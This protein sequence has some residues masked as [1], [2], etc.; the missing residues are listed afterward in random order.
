MAGKPLS[1]AQPLVQPPRAGVMKA[2]MA[3][4]EDSWETGE[5]GGVGAAAG[6][7]ADWWG[8]HYTPAVQFANKKLITKMAGDSTVGLTVS[9]FGGEKDHALI[10]LIKPALWKKHKGYGWGGRKRDWLDVAL[11]ELGHWALHAHSEEH[12]DEFKNWA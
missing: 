7:L 5:P 2:V 8:L 9:S 1:G 4:L 12:A 11:H 10:S 3:L 6:L